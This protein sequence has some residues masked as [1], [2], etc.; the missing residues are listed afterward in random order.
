[1]PP[2]YHCCDRLVLLWKC[3]LSDSV[4]PAQRTIP[5]VLQTRPRLERPLSAEVG[6]S[7]ESVRALAE[8]HCLYMAL[9]FGRFDRPASNSV[10][11]EEKGTGR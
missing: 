8:G 4:A 7:L 5:I 10:I 1:M 9:C 11:L 3:W 2:E 6:L